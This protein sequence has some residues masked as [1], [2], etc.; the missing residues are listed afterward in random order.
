MPCSC[1][2]LAATGRCTAQSVRCHSSPLTQGWHARA[3]SPA[4]DAPQASWAS[5]SGSLHTS[6]ALGGLHLG[7]KQLGWQ[8][9]GCR[10]L[11]R[12]VCHVSPPKE[13]EEPQGEAAE[14]NDPTVQPSNAS[15][16]RTSWAKL[17]VERQTHLPATREEAWRALRELVPRD[18]WPDIA[19]VF[20]SLELIHR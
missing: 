2:H 3:C 4:W 13:L 17:R 15:D 9:R 10:T 1:Y 12:H 8:K 18:Q 7:R 5:N 11:H 14:T 20:A 6:Q 16:G 19:E